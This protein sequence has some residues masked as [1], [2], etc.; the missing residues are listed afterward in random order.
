M[1]KHRNPRQRLSKPQ[2]RNNPGEKETPTNY[3]RQMLHVRGDE[4]HPVDLV[5]ARRVRDRLASEKLARLAREVMGRI[6]GDKQPVLE[7]EALRNA[8][9]TDREEAFFNVGYEHGSRRLP[10]PRAPRVDPPV[11]R[12]PTVRHRNPRTDGPAGGSVAGRARSARVP[13]GAGAAP[14][15]GGVAVLRR[16]TK[17][18]PPKRASRGPTPEIAWG[19]DVGEDGSV[20]ETL[21]LKRKTYAQPCWSQLQRVAGP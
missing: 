14:G 7:L 6:E 2:T 9:S 8:I 16:K 19:R 17:G 12:G 5:V 13:L 18:R 15:R 10:R 11:E 4:N 20:T 3:Y 21:T 1:P